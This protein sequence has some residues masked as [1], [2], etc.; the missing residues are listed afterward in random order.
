MDKHGPA[1]PLQT[2]KYD[3]CTINAGHS[4]YFGVESEPGRSI[5]LSRGEMTTMPDGTQQYSPRSRLML[6]ARDVGRLITALEW[7]ASNAQMP[8]VCPNGCTEGS[9]CSECP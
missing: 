9:A 5:V 4:G 8:V 6:D 2:G 7:A 1:R 3:I